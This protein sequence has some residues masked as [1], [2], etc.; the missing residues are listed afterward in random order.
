MIFVVIW[1]AVFPEDEPR[2]CDSD[3]LSSKRKQV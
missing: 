3:N 1:Q 2:V